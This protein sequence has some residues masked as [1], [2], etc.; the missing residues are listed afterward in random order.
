MLIIFI[1]KLQKESNYYKQCKLSI[2]ILLIYRDSQN[3][4][5]VYNEGAIPYLPSPFF[6]S[7]S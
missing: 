5:K 4:V 7:R 1:E 2:I 3:E 6:H